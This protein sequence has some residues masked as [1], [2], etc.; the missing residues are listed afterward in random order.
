MA[1][2]NPAEAIPEEAAPRQVKFNPTEAIPEEQGASQG[3]YIPLA[4]TIP[5]E[6]FE[7]IAKGIGSDVANIGNFLTRGKIPKYN[8]SGPGVNVGKLLPAFALG[9]VGEGLATL[10][11]EGATAASPLIDSLASSKVGSPITRLLPSAAGGAASS[12][13]GDDTL[14]DAERGA[15]IGAAL[16]PG[17]SILSKVYPAARRQLANLFV[18][19]RKNV[20]PEEFE[21]ARAAI[22]EGIKAPIGELAKSPRAQRLYDMAKGAVFSGADK[23]Y[24]QLYD[25]L[26]QG[27]NN[28]SDAVP[29]AEGL[30]NDVYNELANKYKEAKQ[31]T[32]DAYKDLADYSDSNNVP[33]DRTALDRQIDD[34]LAELKKSNKNQ[35]T[36]KLYANAI[37]TLKDYKNT[38]LNSFDDAVSVRP[39]LGDLISKSSQLGQ[40]DAV[41]RRHLQK[42]KSGLDESLDQSALN[43]DNPDVLDLHKRTLDARKYQGTFEKLNKR[44][45][46]P[47]YKIHE[48]GGD[49]GRLLSQYLKPSRANT[50]NDNAGILSSLTDKLEPETIN[51]IA[52]GYLNPDGQ[53]TLANQLNRLKN[54]STN[55][56]NILFGENATTAN[57]LNEL[58]NLY[59]KSKSANFT[60][61]TGY[62]GSKEKQAS[63]IAKEIFKSIKTPSALAAAGAYTGGGHG[64]LLG[65]AIWPLAN[66]ALQRYLRSDA[67]KNEYL[68]YLRGLPAASNKVSPLI[69]RAAVTTA[70][71]P[72][73]KNGS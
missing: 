21:A 12:L 9:P 19:G 54:L 58:S 14:K 38:P 8:P 20:T 22:P 51:R 43:S 69:N 63:D 50:L 32:S 28:L 61:Q 5:L 3:P 18:G 26:T 64:A 17:L 47:F 34:S 71:S 37:N 31:I 39:A 59:A 52:A 57:N 2:F 56:R 11:I 29:N 16:P 60:P 46:T 65:S 15:L 68:N 6:S 27:V 49:S 33:F 45:Q 72:R 24:E 13:G 35:T 48:K 10:G 40:K 53:Q 73:S 66:Q 30:N 70:A 44:D 67:L 25:H 62:T 41:I 23:P 55:Q 42:L 7:G 4:S 36:A 1:K